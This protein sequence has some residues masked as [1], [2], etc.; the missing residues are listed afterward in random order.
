MQRNKPGP[1]P[2][3]G[4]PQRNKRFEAIAQKFEE[5]SNH[6]TADSIVQVS[7][8]DP[9]TGL[10]KSRYI[11]VGPSDATFY[12]SEIFQPQS[13]SPLDILLTD[14]GFYDADFDLEAGGLGLED[15]ANDDTPAEN[16][17]G[18]EPASLYQVCEATHERHGGLN[19]PL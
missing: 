3:R 14:G 18:A 1:K 10:V 7:T 13:L 19:R 9:E 16:A 4:V 17:G 8:H 2:R 6:P 12:P 15:D 5:K 11:H